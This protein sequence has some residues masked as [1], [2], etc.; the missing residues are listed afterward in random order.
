MDCIFIEGLELRARIGVWDWERQLD[1]RLRV[2]LELGV[3]TRPAAASDALEDAI[4][5]AA[6]AEC[7]RETAADTAYQLLE[8]LAEHLADGVRQRFAVPWLRLTVHKPGAVAGTRSVG[9]RIERA[10][11]ATP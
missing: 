10:Q 6:V 4:S 11:E 2:D 1:Q 5:Y 9:V 3:D 7:L 8:S